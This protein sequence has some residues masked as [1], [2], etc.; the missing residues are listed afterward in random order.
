MVQ[1][2]ALTVDAYLAEVSPERAVVL[3]KLRELARRVL[4]DHEEQMK[5]G[6][7][8][9]VRNGQADFAFASQVQHVAL[10]VT[11]TDVMA[12]HAATLAGLEHGKGCIR[13]RRP[14]TID[15]SFV[16]KLLI[17]TRDSH[18]RPCST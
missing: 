6:M 5:Y 8:T 18:Q 7:P 11:K 16:E 9:Y 15:W 4:V 1:S 13:Y 17:D 2:K 10:Y 14:E 3:R 12:N